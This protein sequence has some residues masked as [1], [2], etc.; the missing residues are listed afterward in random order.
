MRM[1]PTRGESARATA[2]A[3][4]RREARAT[5]RRRTPDEPHADLIAG[6]PEAATA[7]D[8]AC[9][10]IALVRNGLAAAHPDLAK[11]DLK[12]SVRRTLQ[13]LRIAVNGELSAL[14]ALL[15]SLPQC[16]APG[17]RVAILTF[18]SG[19]DRR[20]KKAFQ[21]GLSRRAST[22]PWR[23]TS[24]DRRGKNSCEPARP[25]AK[26]R[27]AVRATILSQSRPPFSPCR[28]RHD[29][30]A[31]RTSRNSRWIFWLVLAEFAPRIL[32]RTGHD[33]GSADYRGSRTG[34]AVQI[35]SM[36]RPAFDGAVG[37]EA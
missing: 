34:E 22:P 3:R 16:L 6:L 15:R 19:E 25:A 32:S 9:R 18:H 21:A 20:V 23:P 33:S 12:L 28:M 7:G 37:F 1:N 30:A 4:E 27:W 8:D 29:N 26:L 10:W 31:R 2:R 13:A 17:G 35:F 11:A 5:A 14:D 24:F 36:P